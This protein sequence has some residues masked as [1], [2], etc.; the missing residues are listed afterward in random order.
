VSILP[1]LLAKHAET[2][3]GA[4]TRVARMKNTAHT[5][6]A[7]LLVLP[8]CA[9]APAPEAASSE[10]VRAQDAAAARAATPASAAKLQTFTS[11]ANGFDTHSYWLD[12]G[13]EVVVFDAQFTNEIA[14]RLAAEIQA[15]TKSPIKYVVVTHPNPDKLN[16]AAVF[17]KLGAKVVASEATA[18]AI[19]GVHA[20][21]KHYFVNMAKM[22][23]EAS[24]PAE[25]R[26]DVTFRGSY[27]LPLEG[28]ATIT[29]KELAHPGVS[30]TQTVAFL[31]SQRALVVGDLVHH[32]AHAWLEGGIV[33]GKPAPDLGEWKLALEELRAF[34]GTTV[35]GGRGASAPVGEA[36][37][38]QAAYLDRVSGI[39]RDYV[40]ALGTR[41][42]ELS[43]PQAA[44]HHKKIA[45]LVAEAFPDYAH[46]YL[47][48][49][50]V[51]GLAGRLA[52]E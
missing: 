5:L 3:S 39:V 22:F 37:L 41:K 25:A 51:Y 49:Y 1:Y 46:P 23:T 38:A 2:A 42:A 17:Q 28:D 14:A 26:V 50:G 34:E 30:S 24:Y 31:P 21:K 8:A 48:E 44:E 11:D 7:L 12:T 20:Y 33:G 29:L 35:Y 18:K 9:A 13:R 36:V 52:A 40:K 45:A 32:K 19:A 43:G 6:L 47:V 27:E 4:D 15:K 10:P 16:G